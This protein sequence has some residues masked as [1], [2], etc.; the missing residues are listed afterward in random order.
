VELAE[1]YQGDNGLWQTAVWP[2][3][4]DVLLSALDP[5]WP[6]VLIETWDGNSDWHEATVS[7]GPQDQPRLRLTGSAKSFVIRVS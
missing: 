7:V 4:A 6:F 1:M 3:R 2:G 5:D